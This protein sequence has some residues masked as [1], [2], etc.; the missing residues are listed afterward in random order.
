MEFYN[1]IFNCQLLSRIHKR[2][3]KPQTNFKSSYYYQNYYQ[4]INGN[5]TLFKFNIL[6]SDLV[7]T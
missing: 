1:Y 3:N 7:M 5:G 4:N 2:D 6:M